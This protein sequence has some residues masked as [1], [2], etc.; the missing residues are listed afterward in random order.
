MLNP[1]GLLDVFVKTHIT[2]CQ[3]KG[4]YHKL[5]EIFIWQV[6][7]MSL[8]KASVLLKITQPGKPGE[9]NLVALLVMVL[10]NSEVCILCFYPC[11]THLWGMYWHE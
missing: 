9:E 4:L 6:M 3:K 1:A 11:P 2:Q 5:I 7:N 10:E 8:Q